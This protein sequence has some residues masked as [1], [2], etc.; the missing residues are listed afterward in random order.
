MD[1]VAMEMSA[2]STRDRTKVDDHPL[3]LAILCLSK[4]ASKFY[5]HP[6]A[7]PVCDL[8]FS[9]A[10]RSL[11]TINRQEEVGEHDEQAVLAFHGAVAGLVKRALTLCHSSLLP[12]YGSFVILGV[13]HGLYGDSW[14]HQPLSRDALRGA[15]ESLAGSPRQTL[16][17]ALA[18]WRLSATEPQCAHALRPFLLPCMCDL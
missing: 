11:M 6:D 5:L 8:A 10:C 9:T 12:H 17:G 13:A 4:A 15:A 3:S 2:L 18:R 1:D 14:Y 16:E 7:R